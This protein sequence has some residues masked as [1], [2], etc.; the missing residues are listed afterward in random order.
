[1]SSLT[2]TGERVEARSRS[3]LLSRAPVGRVPQ[4]LTLITRQGS[5]WRQEVPLP[6]REKHLGLA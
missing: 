6:G 5:C 1:M 2:W 3:D 4:A